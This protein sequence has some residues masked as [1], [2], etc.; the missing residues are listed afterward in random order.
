MLFCFVWPELQKAII[1]S[2]SV[3]IKGMVEGMVYLDSVI[4]TI[5]RFFVF[6]FRM[7]LEIKD[8]TVITSKIMAELIQYYSREIISSIAMFLIGI[9]LLIR[10]LNSEKAIGT[11]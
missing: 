9:V 7:S 4:E 1:S 11:N 2:L 5:L 6:G 3:I 10:L 8:I